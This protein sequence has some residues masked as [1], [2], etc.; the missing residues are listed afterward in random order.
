MSKSEILKRVI[1][2]G[3]K[4]IDMISHVG[5]KSYKIILIY[6]NVSQN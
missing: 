5:G 6:R 2:F 1:L 4:F 3:L